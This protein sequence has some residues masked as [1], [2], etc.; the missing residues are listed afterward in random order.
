MPTTP[1]LSQKPENCCCYG[2][3]S[4]LWTLKTT[5]FLARKRWRHDVTM[6]SENSQ[7]YLWIPCEFYSSLANQ[8][9]CNKQS[10]LELRFDVS[11]TLHLRQTGHTCLPYIII[12]HTCLTSQS[13]PK[14]GH[15]VWNAKGHLTINRAFF[16]S[17]FIICSTNTFE[18]KCAFSE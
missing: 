11:P 15:L 4:R 14:I 13:G 8:N 7:G 18:S 6:S 3:V 1:C 12:S 17:I 5:V 10:A 2:R 9:M 16:P